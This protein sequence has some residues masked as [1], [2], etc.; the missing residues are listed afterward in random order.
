MLKPA[1]LVETNLETHALNDMAGS[2]FCPLFS[3]GL[4]NCLQKAIAAFT[5]LQADTDDKT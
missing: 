5:P 2:Y 1:A 3:F 4:G